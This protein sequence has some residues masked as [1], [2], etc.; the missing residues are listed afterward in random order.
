MFDPKGREAA[1]LWAIE[2][3]SEGGV[4]GDDYIDGILAAYLSTA[5]PADVAGLAER[6]NAVTKRATQDYDSRD[7]LMAEAA[8]ALQTVSAR[9]GEMERALEKIKA[10]FA[11]KH[12]V[13]EPAET[14]REVISI[15]RAAIRR[16]TGGE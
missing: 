15:T 7:E 16:A 12:V 4:P 8:T 5:T 3:T 13:G 10:A 6:L 14:E 9:C 1:R 11:V 2:A